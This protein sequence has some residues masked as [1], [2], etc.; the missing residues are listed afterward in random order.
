MIPE[1]RRLIGSRITAARRESGLTQREIAELLGVTIRTIQNYE[2]GAVIPY[3][4]LR[5]IEA[6]THRR[7]GWILEGNQANDALVD[8]IAALQHT[9]DRHHA[10]L[11]THLESLRRQTELLREQREASEARRSRSRN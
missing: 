7:S 5:R 4:H 8:T 10:L 6:I 3:R 11:N 1:E 9:M 2:S